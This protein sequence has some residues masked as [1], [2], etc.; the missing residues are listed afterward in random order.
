MLTPCQTCSN[1]YSYTLQ[2]Y[3]IRNNAQVKVEIST[4]LMAFYS[5]LYFNLLLFTLQYI[6]I[7]NY[8]NKREIHKKRNNVYFLE[9]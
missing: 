5:T 8:F 7:V 6:K 4:T 1:Q 3:I 9:M 2:D